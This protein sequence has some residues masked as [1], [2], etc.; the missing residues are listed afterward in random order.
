MFYI[1]YPKNKIA[2]SCQKLQ[3]HNFPSLL[4]NQVFRQNKKSFSPLKPKNQNQKSYFPAKIKKSC[5]PAKNE[6]HNY[7]SKPEVAILVKTGKSHFPAKSC[8]PSKSENCVFSPNCILCYFASE[9][10]FLTK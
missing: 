10:V 5:F 3:N 8:F 9:I 2:F 4:E 1:F 6:N 7:L